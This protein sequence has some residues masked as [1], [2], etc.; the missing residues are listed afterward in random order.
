LTSFQNKKPVIAIDGTASSGKGTLAIK[1]SKS[2]G[3]DYLDSG[4]LYRVYAYEFLKRSKDLSNIE[5]ITIDFSMFNSL[6]KLSIKNLRSEEISKAASLIAKNTHVRKSLINI[7]R[8][9]ADH[10]KGGKGSVIDGRDITS[11]IIP[12]AEIKFYV[13]ANIKIRAKRRQ[14]QL[15]MPNEKFQEILV[16]MKKRDE[17]DKK[18]KISPLVKTSDSFFI[19]TS[20]ISE[21]E[22]FKI[23]LREVKKKI[24]FI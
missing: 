1:L 7:Q 18:R 5:N 22:V 6:D 4:L 3:F 21:D 13:D 17:N 2:T 9:I 19:D 10:P 23:A 12:K 15:K 11:V 20:H 14:D 24:D 16:E 8:K